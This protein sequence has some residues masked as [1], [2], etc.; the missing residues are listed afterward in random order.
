[1]SDITWYAGCMRTPAGIEVHR[2]SR[3]ARDRKRVLTQAQYENHLR[4]E[5]SYKRRKADERDNQRL[6]ELR[7]ETA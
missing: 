3:R 5:R 2:A 4:F 6:A 1:M 7:G